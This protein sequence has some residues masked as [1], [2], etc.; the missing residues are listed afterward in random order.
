M[1]LLVCHLSPFAQLRTPRRVTRDPG[2]AGSSRDRPS[3]P[4]HDW[5][6]SPRRRRHTTCSHA[7]PVSRKR[8]RM[9]TTD[10]I[11]IELLA[12]SRRPMQS[13]SPRSPRARSVRT[14]VAG[15]SS[16]CQPS[17]SSGLSA[18][19]IA[20]QAIAV[21]ISTSTLRCLCSSSKM[22]PVLVVQDEVDLT[23]LI[24]GCGIAG[25][26]AHPLTLGMNPAF[27][28]AVSHEELHECTDRCGSPVRRL[29][30]ISAPRQW[31]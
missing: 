10:Q 15:S 18:A 28:R 26:C 27:L 29:S 21:A 16:R 14:A 12:V 6:R 9:G 13:I 4:P 20:L 11:L 22:L 3:C 31:R 7:I 8:I 2:A 5:W 1:V 24:A 19:A 23:A 30:G 17:G 25:P